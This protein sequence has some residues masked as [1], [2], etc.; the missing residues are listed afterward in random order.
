[1]SQRLKTNGIV[2]IAFVV[3][4]CL[5]AA[6]TQR[7]DGVDTPVPGGVAVGGSSVDIA[8]HTPTPAPTAPATVPVSTD[9]PTATP[10]PTE[11]KAPT[12]TPTAGPTSTPRPPPPTPSRKDRYIAIAKEAALPL[13]RIDMPDGEWKASVINAGKGQELQLTMPLNEAFDNEQFVRLA[14]QSMAQVFNAL[15]VSDPDLVRIAIIGT[16]PRTG[17][18]ELPSVSIA[19]Q[20]SAF[21][22]WGTVLRDEIDQ[23]AEFVDI[24]E[25]YR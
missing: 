16:Y 22:E 14:K 13:I 18:V 2:A 9:T 21:A 25:P 11:T 15:F 6:V 24:K 7:G 19:I 17:S 20:R 8:T 1:M 10:P 4:L 12:F 5:A 3:I 23:R